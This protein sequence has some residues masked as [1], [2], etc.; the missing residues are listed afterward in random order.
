MTR[1]WSRAPRHVDPRIVEL[2][3]RDFSYTDIAREVGCTYRWAQYV[4]TKVGLGA[5]KVV[6]PRIVELRKRGLSYSEIARNVG[7][8]YRWAQRV[9]A[10]VG[11][12]ESR[13]TDPSVAKVMRPMPA[14]G[15][16][17]T[18][19][20]ADAGLFTHRWKFFRQH[21]DRHNHLC[22]IVN[23]GS[24]HFGTE[25][26]VTVEFVDGFRVVAPRRAIQGVKP[27]AKW[28]AAVESGA[29]VGSKATK[30]P[31]KP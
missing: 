4:C 3:R 24:W 26:L 20:A 28:R 22:R 17:P 9:C 19:S 1:A 12:T 31:R 18:P 7:V 15:R 16:P 2:R 29:R 11:L 30:R 27:T 13:N 21:P 8:T 6:N 23:P 25:A 14:V 10:E 5:S